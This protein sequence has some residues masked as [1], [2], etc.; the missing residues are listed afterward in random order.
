MTLVISLE[1]I[2]P[3]SSVRAVEVNH[4]Y[5]LSIRD[6]I[7]V[8]CNTNNN[9]A[10]YIWRKII[11][12]RQKYISTLEVI[13]YR[14]PGQG[15]REMPVV[16]LEGAIELIMHLPGPTA[17]TYRTSMAKI[18]SRYITG[19]LSLCNEIKENKEAGEAQSC[20]K[21]I[22]ATVQDTKRKLDEMMED[23]PPTS[24]IYATH[25]VA[26][27]GLVKIG[28]S[29]NVKARLESGNTF[30]APAPHVLIAMAP[31]FDDVRDEAEAHAHFSKFRKEGEFF[32]ISHEEAKN[33]LDSTIRAKHFQ[34]LENYSSGAKGSMIFV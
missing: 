30:I 22:Q 4:I 5:Y 34:E 24:Y 14:F 15:Q 32:K 1:E 18:I 21:F 12:E 6:I 17:K 11:T 29:R 13:Q 33:Y 3:N 23:V 19:D 9:Y 2:A 7:M 27:P 8:V 25:S 28:R 16:P 20:S 31:T 10:G 26:F